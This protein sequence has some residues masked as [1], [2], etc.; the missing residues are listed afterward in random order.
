MEEKAIEPNYYAIIPAH[1]RYDK[2]LTPNAKLLYGEITA[3]CNSKG[4]CWAN[5]EYFANLYDVSK[6]SI[7]KWISSLIEQKH[8]ASQLI[9]KEG[10][11]E[12][13]NRYL[14]IVLKPIEEKLNSPMQVILKGAIEEKLKDNTTVLNNTITNITI[15]NIEERKLKFAETLK[16]YLSTYG[17]DM[18]NDFYIYWSEENKSNTKFKQETMKTWNTAGRL[19]TWNKNNF[20]NKKTISTEP[21]RDLTLGVLNL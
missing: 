12:I 4:Y 11:K 10:T 13:L 5:N 3:L 8:I 9:Y 21:T 1:V 19:R 16:P 6:T 17:K 20:G 2:E 14:T 18:L 7:S 15:N